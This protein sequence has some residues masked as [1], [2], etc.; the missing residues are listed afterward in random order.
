M[1]E[2]AYSAHPALTVTADAALPAL[3]LAALLLP[4]IAQRKGRLAC[5][6]L[7]WICAF[8]SIAL[9]YAVRQ[10]DHQIGWWASHQ[11]R[12]SSHT[13]LGISVAVTLS[14][15]RPV[16]LPLLAVLLAGYFW[17]IVYL[18]YHHPADIYTTAAAILPLS[19]LCHLPWALKRRA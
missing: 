1:T 2:A 19:L 10:L 18:Q 11:L 15:F 3:C 5:P 7:F 9:L 17:L 8:G 13:A 12:F 6:G 16:L 4:A 14:V